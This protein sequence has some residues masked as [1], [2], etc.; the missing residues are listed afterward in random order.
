MLNPT[1]PQLIAKV[2][3]TK[4]IKALQGSLISSRDAVARVIVFLRWQIW[5]PR[6]RA[7]CISAT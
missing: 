4:G 3:I 6:F 5:M 2:R 1:S 7:A